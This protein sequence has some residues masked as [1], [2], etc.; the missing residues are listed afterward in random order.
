MFHEIE[1]TEDCETN[2]QAM[3]VHSECTAEEIDYY[4]LGCTSSGYYYDKANKACTQCYA[5]C[6]TCTGG[7][8]ENCL[9]CATDYY[10]LTCS[11]KDG[12]TCIVMSSC[13]YP[14]YRDDESKTCYSYL[15]A[16][17][18]E[19]LQP[20]QRCKSYSKVD[21]EFNC[22]ECVSSEY[23]RLRSKCGSSI[24]SDCIAPSSCAY[25]AVT[26]DS[27]GE[28]ICYKSN[29]GRHSSKL[30]DEG[31]DHVQQGLCWMC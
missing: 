1:T 13:L 20:S 31:R 15:C 21:S 6:G 27:K 28:V 24:Y 14:M 4:C 11:V 29:S 17:C 16:K 10:N 7:S 26:A 30:H 8:S 22:T 12:G 9:T 18:S 23:A 2:W 5:S 19:Y 3:K 25:T